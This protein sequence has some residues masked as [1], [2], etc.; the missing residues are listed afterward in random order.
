MLTYK[1]AGVDIR[2]TSAVKRRIGQ[3]V[4][5]TY[6]P[7]VLSEI[8]LF[9]SLYEL[10][11]YKHPVL[12][13][14]CD[15][16]GTKLMVARMM[17][18]HDTVGEDIVNHSV[19]DIL[20]LGARPLFFLDYIA[21]AKLPPKVV[22]D[23]IK[24]LVR[25]C[26]RNGCALI[27]G[28]TAMM[29]GL[30]PKGDY[31]LAGMIVGVVEKQDIIKPTRIHAGDVIIGLPS[32]GLHT[33]GFSLA[34]KVLFDKMRLKVTDRLPLP[35]LR[36]SR[37]PVSSSPIA[38]RLSPIVA[39]S[40]QSAVRSPQSTVGSALLRVHRSYQ[41]PLAPWLKH[42]HA[43]AHI[44]GGG[45]KENIERLL[46]RR[47]DC[48]IY[49]DSWRVPD[50]FRVIQQGGKVPDNEMYHVFNMGI[51]MVVIADK[52]LAVKMLSSIRDA[53]LI[54]EAINGTGS[55]TLR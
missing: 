29:P 24:G 40:P 9:G 10:K 45:F 27:G 52:R 6:S 31:D 44:T 14:S 47:V 5:T 38:Y 43:L 54:G 33:N 1:S 16:V 2:A 50:I 18:K 36:S 3:M 39:R 8:G 11:G 46:P 12:V 37:S 48:I 42:V 19:N 25:G 30:Y 32:T 55:V 35:A 15:G 49:K 4:R 23:V 21:Y 22:P 28:E 26:K 41:A 51:G 7:Q 13:A 53:R 34:R 17:N 20:T